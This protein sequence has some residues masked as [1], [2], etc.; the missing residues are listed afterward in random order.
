MMVSG[1]G[2]RQVR[3]FSFAG[4]AAFLELFFNRKL[5]FPVFEDAAAMS[6]AV[7]QRGRHLRVTEH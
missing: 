4:L 2:V 6:E 7:E 5:S 1:S 3:G